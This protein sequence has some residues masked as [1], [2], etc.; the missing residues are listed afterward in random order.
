MRFSFFAV[1]RT[2]N[3][4]AVSM[5][6][7]ALDHLIDNGDGGTAEVFTVYPRQDK[8]LAKPRDRVT[9]RDGTPLKLVLKIIPL[10]LA[11]RFVSFFFRNVPGAFFGSDIEALIHSNV[12]IT[13]GGTTFSDAQIIKILYNVA[14]ALPGIILKKPTMFY[15]Q[16]IGP[17]NNIFN[18]ICA[19]FILK[20]ITIVSP[21]G[22]ES[23]MYVHELGID[24]CE[25]LSD[26]AFT[27]KIPDITENK[28][29][30][31]FKKILEGKTVVGI[32][33]NTIV[34]QKSKK[35][36][37]DHNKEWKYFIEWLQ[38]EG[39]FVL[40]IPHSIRPNSKSLHNNDL[41]TV[42]K[43]YHSLKD[44]K[45]IYIVDYHYDCKELRIIV[46]L[47]DYYIASRFHSM[48]SALCT[49]T[50]VAVFGWG[51]QKYIEVLSDFDLSNY[52]YKAEDLSF[53]NLKKSFIELTLN[54]DDIIEKM[55]HNLPKVQLSSMKNHQ[56]TLDL[57][58]NNK[59]LN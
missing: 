25:E 42:N 31:D 22:R 49:E 37:I 1:S 55:R 45:N 54:K 24:N 34:E 57:A 4:G 9:L 27:L 11:Y 12:I 23:L 32:S 20:R 5:L 38:D 14:C 26:S 35:I 33:V 10:C 6:E 8:E 41:V 53:E 43:I 52:C 3:R 19:K 15:S 48:I 47:S 44:K 29:K 2:G 13:A 30:N 18:R 46:G 58:K 16:T 50:P 51:Y 7:S 40:L 17:F 21:R 39:Y 36:G 56:K 59:I 28:I